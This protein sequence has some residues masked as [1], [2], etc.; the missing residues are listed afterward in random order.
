MLQQSQDLGSA[1]PSFKRKLGPE[2]AVEKE[3]C[4]RYVCAMLQTI[5][6]LTIAAMDLLK[7]FPTSSCKHPVEVSYR[8]RSPRGLSSPGR[9]F[10]RWVL[11]HLNRKLQ[12][13]LEC[14]LQLR[15]YSC[16]SA[17]VGLLWSEV[18]HFC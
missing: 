17:S 9:G 4:S 2:Q 5:P 7:A 8:P 6:T 3:T 13:S 1:L 15:T 18:L 10:D 12:K 11:L 16:N 14:V